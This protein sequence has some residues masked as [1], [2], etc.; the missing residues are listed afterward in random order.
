MLKKTFISAAVVALLAGAAHA[1]L[2][3]PV[4]APEKMAAPKAAAPEP[5]VAPV[6]AAPAAPAVIAAPAE[7]P[8]AD[9][10]NPFIGKSI[11]LEAR[12]RDLEAAK[13]ETALLEE[14]IKQAALNEDLKTIPLKKSVEA[15]QAT[16]ARLK[17]EALQKDS[18]AKTVGAPTGAATPVAAAQGGAVAAP[19]KPKTR[20]AKKVNAPKAEAPK[21]QPAAAPAVPKVEVTSVLS[22]G[23]VRSAVLEIDG[24][25]L[26]V[27]H[28][29]STPV[30]NVE[31][32]DTQ[33]VRVGGRIYR[34]HGAT[35]ARITISDPKPVD[36]KAGPVPAA[37]PAVAT[38][39]GAPPAASFPGSPNGTTRPATPVLP[40]LQLPAGVTLIPP[41]SR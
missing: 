23:G 1:Q 38:T 15:A 34:V 37:V 29:D 16:T 8:K 12:Q 14:R 39:N 2:N 13:L 25:I 27:R 22:L 32:L 28:G 9:A 24:N 30:G 7:A 40:P 4:A 35:L 31:V 41:T 10:V 20:P 33:S 19:A 36:P 21:E 5:V 26:T 18:T 11:G 6:V 17:E 3:T